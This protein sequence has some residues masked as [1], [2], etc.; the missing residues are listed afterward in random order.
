MTQLSTEIDKLSTQIAAVEIDAASGLKVHKPSDAGGA[1]G[2]LHNLRE[3]VADQDV[4][5]DNA[6]YAQSL[7]STAEEAVNEM[8]D[9]FIRARELAVQMASET[10][11]T[12]D[13]ALAALEVQG[14]L[15]DIVQMAN[16]E[17]DGRFLFAGTTYD[18]EAYDSTGTY[19]G[20]NNTTFTMVS[21]RL[22]VLTGFD[23]SDIFQGTTDIFAVMTS[24]ITELNNDDPD[25]IS[26][27]V[28]DV[29]DAIS[30]VSHALTRIGVEWASAEDAQELAGTL[31]VTLQGALSTITDADVTETYTRLSALQVAYEAAL[32]V[33]ASASQ[34]S[35][36]SYL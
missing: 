26:V 27:I 10:Y 3:Q 35:L 32:Q 18:S 36:F 33:T 1:I 17:F 7:L 20:S 30:Q 12:E 31:S 21:D 19:L 29:D 34:S 15:E 6:S 14:L 23:G 24:L 22:D 8:V 28:G 13:R 5:K 2:R 25:A 16:I 9:A 11:D 4:W